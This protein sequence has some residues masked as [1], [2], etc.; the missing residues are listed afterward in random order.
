LSLS[1]TPAPGTAAIDP[2]L[3]ARRI[4]VRRA[5]ARKRLRRL[6]ALG[7]VVGV[8]LVGF[9]MTR[10]PL[11]DVDRIEL[12]GNVRTPAEVI[13]QATG[14]ARHSPMTSIDI[15]RARRHLLALPWVESASVSREWPATVRVEIVERVAIAAVPAGQV[16]IALVDRTGRV[17]SIEA[18]VPPDLVMLDGLPPASAPGS[19]LDPVSADVLAVAT[20]LTPTLKTY[21]GA[22]ARGELGIELRLR[23]AGIVRVGDATDLGA[24]LL[25]AST[26]LAQVDLG[27]LCAIDVRVP[28]APSLTRGRSCL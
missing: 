27:Y 28:S 4:S 17:L 2:R 15:D 23:E 5:Q 22:V 12:T 6:I 19:T 20:A 13:A 24:K 11:L 16:G 7:V 3:R 10:S 26:V 14:I 9:A 21:V 18:D 8:L 25:A 1:T